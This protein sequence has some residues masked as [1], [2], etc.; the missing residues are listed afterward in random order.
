MSVVDTSEM[1]VKNDKDQRL[2][3]SNRYYIISDHF[4]MCANES[5]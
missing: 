3:V 5:G 4:G 2:D 1:A